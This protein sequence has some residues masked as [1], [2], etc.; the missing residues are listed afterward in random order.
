M[1]YRTF[2]YN[3]KAARKSAIALNTINRN[4][5]NNF[6]EWDKGNEPEHSML[7]FDT[8]GASKRIKA[9]LSDDAVQKCVIHIWNTP[10]EKIGYICVDTMFEYIDQVWPSLVKIALQMQL[11]V[12][13]AQTGQYEF[14]PRDFRY[15]WR[16]MALRIPD[17]NEQIRK[18]T[19]SIWRL[20]KLYKQNIDNH[21]EAAYVLTLDKNREIPLYERTE[22]FYHLLES[23]LKEDEKL[24][25]QDQCFTIYG[26]WYTISYTIEAYRKNADT[27]CYMLF[28]TAR[29]EKLHR[30]SCER[31][32]RWIKDHPGKKHSTYFEI[33]ERVFF[34]EMV[35]ECPNPA[36][37]FCASLNITKALQKEKLDIDY[38]SFQGFGAQIMIHR[39]P[40][41]FCL[42]SDEQCRDSISALKIG[43]ELATFILPFVEEEYP[44]F[45]ERYYLTDNHIPGNMLRKIKDRLAVARNNLYAC[46]NLQLYEPYLEKADFWALDSNLEYRERNDPAKLPLLIEKYRLSIA[47][48]YDVFVQWAEAQ[49]E[50][51]DSDDLFNITGP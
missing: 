44:Y 19:V 16:N 21:P 31:A 28:D 51:G 46:T 12:L 8:E 43:E 32:L 9:D 25:I 7:P 50:H 17:L 18:N 6:P 41:Q 47:H 42:L 36:D 27:R 40:N 15:A 3:T 37:R 35:C 5:R 45:Y 30:I 29:V 14:E 2:L 23:L 38:S 10:I 39:V 1:R 33:V 34:T 24:S 48:L 11:V 22:A 26:P 20:R 13:D 49:L 4:L